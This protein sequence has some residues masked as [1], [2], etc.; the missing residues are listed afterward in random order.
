MKRHSLPAILAAVFVLAGSRAASACAACFGQSD[1][2][3]ARSL[4][5]S[6][7]TLM[8]FIGVVLI[9]AVSFFVFLAKKAAA[10]VPAEQPPA[11]PAQHPS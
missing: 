4:N 6:I 10:S 1:S 8:A 9:G 2:S 5:A 3:M 7:F 11:P